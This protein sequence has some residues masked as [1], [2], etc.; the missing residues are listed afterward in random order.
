MSVAAAT[1]LK[2]FQTFSL[3]VYQDLETFVIMT[4]GFKRV[5]VEGSLYFQPP[6]VNMW[7]I[8]VLVDVWASEFLK[9]EFLFLFLFFFLLFNDFLLHIHQ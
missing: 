7:V 6:R 9:N 8:P 3:D 5:F 1:V 2:P 4:S